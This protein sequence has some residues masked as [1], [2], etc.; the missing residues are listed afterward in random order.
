MAKE[1]VFFDGGPHWGDLAVNLVFGISV[2]WLPLTVA[3]VARGLLARY[4]FT[5]QRVTIIGGLSGEDRRDFNYKDVK[6]V[7]YVPRFLGDWGDL[8]ISLNNGDQIECQRIPKFK[9]IAAFVEKQAAAAKPGNVTAG[10]KGQ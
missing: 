9:E 6:D 1:Q 4:R 10:A 3:A 2:L 8:V 5:D 7:K